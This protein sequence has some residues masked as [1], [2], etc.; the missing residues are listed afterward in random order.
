M[1]PI[2]DKSSD[3]QKNDESDLKVYI[4]AL[5]I[6]MIGGTSLIL[7]KMLYQGIFNNLDVL[8]VFL[9]GRKRMVLPFMLI[10]ILFLCFFKLDHA[11]GKWFANISGIILSFVPTYF[12]VYTASIPPGDALFGGFC[13]AFAFISALLGYLLGWIFSRLIINVFLN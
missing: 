11:K 13:I 2:T 4:V 6:P 12:F 7:P 5:L 9:D 1:L 8:C 3:F 10:T